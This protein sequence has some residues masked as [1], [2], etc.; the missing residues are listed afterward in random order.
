MSSTSSS[1]T[2]VYSFSGNS[3]VETTVGGIQ[4]S[5]G[6]S[7]V[8]T[9]FDDAATIAM[10]NSIQSVWHTAGFTDVV[11]SITKQDRSETDYTSNGSTFV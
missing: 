7:G 9:S 5:P 3:L 8:P 4:I 2:Y 1:V 11:A 6:A 10:G